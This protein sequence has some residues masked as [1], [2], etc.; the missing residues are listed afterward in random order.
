MSEFIETIPEETKPVITGEE[1]VKPR[2][3]TI[4]P[5][6]S[7]PKRSGIVTPSEEI[8]REPIGK[9]I[10]GLKETKKKAPMDLQTEFLLELM[11]VDNPYLEL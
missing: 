6:P 7:L 1:G 2:A 10:V 8:V 5:L 9:G 4:V 11:N 3:D